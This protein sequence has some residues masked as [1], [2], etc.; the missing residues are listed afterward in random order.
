MHWMNSLHRWMSSPTA[1]SLCWL[2]LGIWLAAS[3]IA[4]G[5]EPASPLADA[6]ERQDETEI[7]RLLAEQV[8]VNATQADGMT[9]LHWAVLHEDADNVR[10]LLSAGADPN[11][12]N[13]YGIPP[14]AVACTNGNPS[15]VEML[16]A[17]GARADATL[18]GGQTMLMTAARTGRVE[19]VSSL[20]A[21]GADV[22]GRD[23]R[24]Q[25]AL[26]WAAAEGHAAVVDSLIRAGADFRTPLESGFTPMFFAVRNGH[27]AVVQRLLAAGI[28]VNQVA[29]V[30]RPSGKGL[31]AGTTPLLLAVENG[32]FELAYQ[33]LQAGADPRDARRGFTV[34][35]AITWVRKP[36]RGD[37]DPPPQGSGGMS[38][39]DFVRTL[40][41]FGADVNARHGP[42]KANNNALN[43]TD[44]TPFLLAA[45][46][47]DLPLMQLLLELGADPRLTNA[48]HCTPL[49]AAAGVGVLGNGDQSAGSEEEAIEV[50]QWLLELGADINAVDDLG[51]SAMHGAT[52]ENR[53]RLLEFLA[54]QGAR[55][56][57]WNRPNNRGW[58]PLDIA[59]GHRPGNFRLVPEARDVLERL[60]RE[61]GIESPAPRPRT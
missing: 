8:D 31:K 48:D 21:R 20:I 6:A 49:L 17:A 12:E 7:A 27:P 35:H 38:S 44:A 54:Q 45:E 52:Y 26:M 3:L 59:H 51:N 5:A 14:L 61:A 36:L 13:R 50:I 9:A 32:H 53:Y 55:V 19:A 47:G 16:L 43:K 30:A 33:L 2:G 28:D 58:T 41:S 42:H 22:D 1:G 4:T 37:G 39:L 29:E 18:R 11:A 25:T 46:T 34:L 10:R 56:A 23:R 60:L 24:G 15:I 57:I 40:V